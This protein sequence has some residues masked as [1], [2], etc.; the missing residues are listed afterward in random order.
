MKKLFILIMIPFLLLCG[1]KE[2]Q[3]SNTK[4]LMDTVCTVTADC[5]EKTLDGAFLLCENYERALSVNSPDS[6]ISLMNF[7]NEYEMS[8]GTR[9]LILKALYYCQKT[10]GHYDIT[11]SPVINAWDF[12]NGVLPN[13]DHLNQM[14]FKVG[15]NRIEITDNKIDLNDTDIDLSSIVKGFVADKTVEY[16]KENGAKNGIVNLGGNVKV[17]GK[18]YTVGIQKPFSNEVLLTVKIKNSSAVTSGIYQRYFENDGVLYHHIL[19]AKTG[20]PVENNLASVTI[21]GESSTECDI[22]STVCMILGEEDA[23]KLIDQTDGYEAVFIDK[24][25][26]FSVSSGLKIKNRTIVYK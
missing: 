22:L 3:I 9:E 5:D 13:F 2:K 4:L 6:D 24:D 23:K 21:L 16:L 20:M 14:L 10:R 18:A 15:Y 7:Y 25:N 12:K 11:L 8:D 19:D 17:F 26:D 1:C